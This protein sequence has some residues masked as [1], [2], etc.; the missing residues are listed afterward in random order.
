M[1]QRDRHVR[2]EREWESIFPRNIRER[3][4]DQQIDVC[5]IFHTH[6]WLFGVLFLA[7]VL[8]CGHS[9]QVVQEAFLFLDH[10]ILQ[11]LIQL[12]EQPMTNSC[13]WIGCWYVVGGVILS[14]V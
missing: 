7:I 11:I 14:H 12:Y 4:E 2:R 1:D 3:G 5:L 6:W 9:P 10:G 13:T 8:R